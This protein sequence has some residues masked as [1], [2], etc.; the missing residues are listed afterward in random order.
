[1]LIG[2]LFA[3]LFASS[4]PMVADPLVLIGLWGAWMGSAVGLRRFATKSVGF[5]PW[6]TN[7]LRLLTTDLAV[8]WRALPGRPLRSELIEPAPG[9]RARKF[10]LIGLQAALIAS[11]MVFGL[12]ILRPAHDNFAALTTL[13][14]S[15]WLLVM[16]QQSR[17]A[18]K[19]RQ[20]RQNFRTFEELDVFASESRMGVIG[21]SPFGI[22]VVSST[23][24]TVGNKIRLAFGLPQADGSSARIEVS[25]SVKRSARDGDHHVAY[26]RFALLTDEHMDRVTEYC[27][28]VAGMRVLRDDPGVAPEGTTIADVVV[29]Q[30]ITT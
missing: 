14:L 6:I 2:I 28:V 25:T 17:S 23:P 26:L 21:V 12:G 3:T 1:M 19:L 22:D 24:F 9:R 29:D 16:C 20:V 27:S 30:P 13:G 15:I 10:F 11:V 7:D 4:L 18:L 8:A 5:T